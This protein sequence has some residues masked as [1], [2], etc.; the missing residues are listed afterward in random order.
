MSNAAWLLSVIYSRCSHDS[1]M[2]VDTDGNGSVDVDEL[3]ALVEK[4][5]ARLGPD[6]G[7]RQQLTE[8]VASAMER[9]GIG[10]DQYASVFI[11]L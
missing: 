10:A 3:S 4:L 9:Y 1:S 8:L 2:Q 11:Y 7:R 6:F 5:S